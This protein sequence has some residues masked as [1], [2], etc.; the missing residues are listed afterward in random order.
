MV[1]CNNMCYGYKSYLIMELVLVI[2]CL[3]EQFEINCPSA[4][5][6][7]LVIAREKRGHFE[8]FKNYEGGL[9][10]KFSESNM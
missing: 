2:T 1:I 5:F 7:N 9:S 8:I 3:E 10:Q 4:F 6:E